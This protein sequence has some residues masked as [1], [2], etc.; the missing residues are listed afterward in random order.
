MKRKRHASHS[1]AEFRGNTATENRD[2]NRPIAGWQSDF[3][4]KFCGFEAAGTR[5][6]GGIARRR[7]PGPQLFASAFLLRLGRQRSAYG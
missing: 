6:N 2:S 1:R 7:P 3:F 4:R 5:A